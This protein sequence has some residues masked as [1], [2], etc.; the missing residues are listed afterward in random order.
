V[1]DVAALVVGLRYYPLHVAEYLLELA[2]MPPVLGCPRRR[3]R[4]ARRSRAWPPLASLPR[5]AGRRSVLA[6]ARG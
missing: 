4:P 2:R 5:L 6:T 1:H 3:W